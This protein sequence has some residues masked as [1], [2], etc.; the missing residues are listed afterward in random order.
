MA[1]NKEPTKP[2]PVA[3][4]ENIDELTDA[5][6]QTLL[7]EIRAELEWIKT[8]GDK[9]VVNT[10]RIRDLRSVEN[11]VVAALAEMSAPLPD[12]VEFTAPEET[13]A[14]EPAP[15]E[16]PTEDPA[17]E[18]APEETPADSK[19]P[20]T[21]PQSVIDAVTA[22]VIAQMANDSDGP[23]GDGNPVPTDEETKE[24]ETEAPEALILAS[25]DGIKISDSTGLDRSTETSMQAVANK[26][27]SA[28]G[29]ISNWDASTE[30][31]MFSVDHLAGIRKELGGAVLG[32]DKDK[33]T[34]LI[35]N[36]R[37]NPFSEPLFAALCGQKQR[38]DIGQE[39]F[40][41]DTSPFYDA[42]G[43]I[44]I[45]ANNC[46][47]E[48]RKHL[49]P[50]LFEDGTWAWDRCKQEALDCDDKATWK[51]AV[52]LPKDCTDYCSAEPFYIGMALRVTVDQEFCEP[53]KIE[54]ASRILRALRRRRLEQTGMF[55]TDSASTLKVHTFDPAFGGIVPNLIKMLTDL[56]IRDQVGD[57]RCPSNLTAFIPNYFRKLIAADIALAGENETTTDARIRSIFAACDVNN[58][59]FH[60]TWG[61]EGEL[62]TPIADEQ[63]EI[64][65]V[66]CDGA[67]PI[68]P[69]DCA[70]IGFGAGT[71]IEAPPAEAS[72]RL[73]DPNSFFKG[74]VGVEDWMLTKDTSSK[75]KNDGLYFGESRHILAPA[76]NRRRFRIDIDGICA[77]GNRLDRTGAIAC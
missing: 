64:C 4:P 58:V 14:E 6:L 1:E 30:M 11:A 56:L 37:S 66:S 55:I 69:I 34:L 40:L 46:G 32:N 24:E 60:D 38:V 72:I 67:T 45:P 13:P 76:D 29:T 10:R 63:P 22:S 7:P 35:A 2:E 62:V 5:T 26:F 27:L 33:N 15:E 23:D 47:I 52:E 65:D 39:C 59:V 50:A 31:H 43:G 74:E 68:D 18:E 77:D 48:W 42:I 54:E 16:D 71:P 36:R 12:A 17:T 53:G 61:C 8:H 75:L 20:D 9:T 19:V 73:L 57:I 21:I 70:A 41:E 51:Q 44:P 28:S 3:L 49:D 25:S